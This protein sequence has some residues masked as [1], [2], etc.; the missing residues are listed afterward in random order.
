MPIVLSQS[1]VDS[2][3]NL[4]EPVNSIYTEIR[5]VI[6]ADGKKLF[7]VVE[8]HPENVHFKENTAAQ[9]VWMSTKDS[10]SGQW[11]KPMH[12]SGVINSGINNG[13]FWVSPDGNRA[14]IR[15]D[16]NKANGKS[17][18]LAFCKFQN[19]E[20]TLQNKLNIPQLE[21][22]NGGK[23]FG[24]NLSAD[25]NTLLLYGTSVIDGDINDLFVSF[26]NENGNWSIPVSIGPDINHEFTNEIT[27]FLAADGI[28]LFFSSNRSGGLGDQD[29]WMSKR[30]DPTWQK[31]SQPINL[32]ASV[33]TKDWDAYLTIDAN[34]DF[35]YLACQQDA[36]QH[37][38]IVRV[39][40]ADSIKPLPMV[41]LFGSV[42][43]ALS[44]KN[45]AGAA[46]RIANDDSAI[47]KIFI[48][49]SDTTGR[50]QVLLPSLTK[51]QVELKKAGYF[52]ITDQFACVE[53]GMLKH[54][55]HRDFYCTSDTIQQF[56]SNIQ[57]QIQEKD[58][59]LVALKAQLENRLKSA[60]DVENDAASKAVGNKVNG[61]A[62]ND[63]VSSTKS[64]AIAA[65][66]PDE[67]NER[68]IKSDNSLVVH[69]ETGKQYLYAADLKILNKLIEFAKSNELMQIKIAGHTDAKGDKKPNMQLSKDRATAIAE[70][71]IAAG[72]S[73]DRIQTF[74]WGYSKPIASNS[75]P[76][77]MA[78]NR[79]VEINL[80]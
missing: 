72:V 45:I 6:S 76:E 10:L 62:S 48:V 47:S 51:Y 42:K 5:P 30:L 39:R 37:S 55:I 61:S 32:G 26:K 52:N 59:A 2:I 56:I 75:V 25:E 14:L 36:K 16:E 41:I 27:P 9:D 58:V 33:N 53:S 20:W 65:R 44:G 70:M 22:I 12:L 67:S 68:E 34:G 35:A 17:R 50:Y 1:K 29:I 11:K 46:I 69:F 15:V 40:L 63:P 57:H 24:A 60:E 49:E 4:G 73:P 79:R 7:F 23:Y 74:Y 13:I 38:D 66:F 54:E 64:Q 77:G 43:E 19:D 21:K 80:H 8:G 31:W 78:K 71:F 28:T 3:L 18:G